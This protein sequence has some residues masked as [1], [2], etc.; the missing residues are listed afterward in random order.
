MGERDKSGS[1]GWCVSASSCM[2][3]SAKVQIYMKCS[4]PT[5]RVVIIAA[6]LVME[7][8]RVLEEILQMRDI[9]PVRILVVN[10][11]EAKEKLAVRLCTSPQLFLTLLLLL[12]F[13]WSTQLRLLDGHPSSLIPP[14]LPGPDIPS[15]P[16]PKPSTHEHSAPP[17][18]NPRYDYLAEPRTPHPYRSAFFHS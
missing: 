6:N 2:L 16:F 4:R 18:T 5:L 15:H 11:K 1:S 14:C 3:Q 10:S 13:T 12:L 9:M 7:H 17:P 8:C